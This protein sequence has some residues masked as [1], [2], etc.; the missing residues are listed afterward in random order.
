MDNTGA[1]LATPEFA[2]G[3]C[4]GTTNIFGDATVT[5][6][7]GARSSGLWSFQTTFYNNT[8]FQ[9][10]K[11]VGSTLTTGTTF[12]QNA[13][14]QVGAASNTADR[15]CM[16]VDITKGSPNYS[17][18]LTYLNNTNSTDISAA[19]FLQQMEVASP[20]L[21]NHATSAAQT[22]AVNEGTDG[23]LDSINFSWNRTT[24]FIEICDIA[25]ARLA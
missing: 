24:P 14:V 5:H 22:I 4:S 7:V 18:T 10:A 20:V 8:S 16:F 2:F 19:T 12:V 11:K 25:V 21:T 3:L 15:G 1:G 17:L 6:F 23:V 9:P 13:A